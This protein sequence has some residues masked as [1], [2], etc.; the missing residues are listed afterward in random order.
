[1]K[2]SVYVALC[3]SIILYG[4]FIWCLQE[5]LFNRFRHFH[6]RCART[7]CRFTIAQTMRHRTSSSSLFQR[8]ELWKRH[9]WVMTF[10]LN[11]SMARDFVW[12]K[13]RACVC[14]SEILSAT[15]ETPTFPRQDIWAELRYGTKNLIRIKI[16]FI[17]TKMC[18]EIPGKQLKRIKKDKKHI[19]SDQPA[20]KSGGDHNHKKL[21]FW[22]WC[23]SLHKS[24]CLL[25]PGSEVG[26]WWAIQRRCLNSV[27]K[28]TKQTVFPK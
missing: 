15:K 4:S 8:T 10:Q 17:R 27:V 2:G 16:Y 3:L 21:L 5:D 22:L 12:S 1:M 23:C 7:M 24:K 14:D 26:E 9:F 18:S 25:T 19:Q 20:S 6:H 11:F 13:S 28:S